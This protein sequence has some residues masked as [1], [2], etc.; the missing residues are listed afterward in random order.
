MM[1]FLKMDIF[2]LLFTWSL[3]QSC[4]SMTPAA[5]TFGT[6]KRTLIL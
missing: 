6:L 2:L 3:W 5:S 1:V 4:G